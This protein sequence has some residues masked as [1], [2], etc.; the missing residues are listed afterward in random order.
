MNRSKPKAE[1]CPTCVKR[2][3]CCQSC[4]RCNDCGHAPACSNKAWGWT[5]RVRTRK[6]LCQMCKK[7]IS[8]PEAEAGDATWDAIKPT[9]QKL[10]VSATELVKRLCAVGA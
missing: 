10:Q 3:L 8:N 2:R 5:G 1:K 4:G 9:K 6:I 7:R